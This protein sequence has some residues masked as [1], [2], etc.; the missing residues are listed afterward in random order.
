MSTPIPKF[1][2]VLVRFTDS[3]SD[4]AEATRNMKRELEKIQAEARSASC[5]AKE[6]A[7]TFKTRH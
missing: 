7:Q 3:L 2:D 6:I 4:F 5:G 1:H